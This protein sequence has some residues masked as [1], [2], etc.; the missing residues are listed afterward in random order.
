MVTGSQIRLA[1][2]QLKPRQHRVL[3]MVGQGLR[4]KA[5]ARQLGIS[6]HTVNKDVEAA[7]RVL[8]VHDRAL[9]AA[10]LRRSDVSA[11][12]EEFVCEE[13]QLAPLPVKAASSPES[14]NWSAAH[15]IQQQA[16]WLPEPAA[17]ARHDLTSGSILTT[18]LKAV[19]II[20]LVILAVRPVTESFDWLSNIINPIFSQP[21]GR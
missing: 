20:L 4:S 10:M 5:I 6:P 9:A 1:V 11:P 14:Q 12:Y 18:Y 3:R 21:G 13:A 15:D 19:V 2:A 16:T 17:E 8:G 7:M